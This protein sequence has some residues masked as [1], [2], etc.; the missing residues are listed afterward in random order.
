MMS[1]IFKLVFQIFLSYSCNVISKDF[2][3]EDFMIP[4]FDY[5]GKF[6]GCVQ[7]SFKSQSI[8]DTA[9]I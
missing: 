4:N 2:V 6:E 8:K 5:R 3:T 1:S 9:G 7:L